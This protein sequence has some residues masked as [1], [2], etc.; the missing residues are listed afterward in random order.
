MALSVKSCFFYFTILARTMLS[1]A[2]IF[3]SVY[4]KGIISQSSVRRILKTEPP[5]KVWENSAPDIYDEAENFWYLELGGDR[6]SIGDTEKVREELLGLATGT[7]DYIKNS[8]N[9]DSAK[10]DLDF[11]GFLPGK[12]ESRRMCGEYMIT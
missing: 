5:D 8:G 7:W 2:E 10:W 4:S 12:R 9:F 1:S 3:S 6:D 11:L